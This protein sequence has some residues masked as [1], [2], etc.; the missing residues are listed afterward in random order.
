MIHS[1]LK[2]PTFNTSAVYFTVRR[3]V[4]FRGLLMLIHVKSG[5]RHY[6]N[7]L[8]LNEDDSIT[9]SKLW[10]NSQGCI[11]LSFLHVVASS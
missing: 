9:F 2:E 1:K 5:P 4:K 8:I 7:L 11:S 3:K 10:I 6:L